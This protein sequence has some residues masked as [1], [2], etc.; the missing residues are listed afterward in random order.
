MRG[1]WK[2]LSLAW[3]L[4]L[5][6]AVRAAAQDEAV[7]RAAMYLTGCAAEEELDPDVVDR[8]EA[9]AGRKIRVNGAHLRPSL[10][11]SE[12]QLASLADYRSRSG[13]I[14]SWEELALVDGFS[15]ETVAVL[16]PFL[17]LESSRLPG[18]V[19]D[20]SAG[21]W[22]GKAL[23]RTT[24]KQVGAKGRVGGEK[25]QLQGAWRDGG[26][27]FSGVWEGGRYRLLAGHF[28]LRFGQGLGVWT[29]FS[30]ENLSTLD[31]FVRRPTGI[32]P[33]WSYNPSGLP[34][35]LACAASW[36]WLQ[37]QLFA[38]RDGSGGLRADWF[39]LRAQAGL[40]LRAAPGD[41]LLSV[42]GRYSLGKALLVGEAALRHRSAGAKVSLTLPLGNDFRLALQARAMPSRFAAKKYGEYALAA[43]LGYR[44]GRRCSLRGKTGFGSSVP[45]FT[46]SLTADAALLPVP[47]SDPRRLQCRLYATA[48]AQLSGAWSLETRLTGRYRNYERARTDLRAD[49]KFASGPWLSVFRCELVRCERW[50]F[51]CYQEGGYKND[52]LSIY[53]RLTGFAIDHWNDRIYCYERDA[54]GNFSVPAYSGRGLSASLAG[55]YKFRL[56]RRVFL[57]THLRAAWMVRAGRTPTPTLNLQ[58]QCDI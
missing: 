6:L 7:L 25:W 45:V 23:L 29:G 16:R 49:V 13:D 51:L 35:G 48:L 21:R 47:A 43:G 18:Q 9:L 44:S 31:A 37:T 58:F 38:T 55:G 52:A 27:T 39:S 46:A 33:V 5:G 41:W 8:L 42:D 1:R 26:G 17:S 22:Q 15:R 10:L 54:P 36:G 28:N 40:T 53:L 57:C 4:A 3:G 12:Y 2:Y 56:G 11:L 34:L 24:L 32:S 19:R 30:M 14:L 50:G 20:S